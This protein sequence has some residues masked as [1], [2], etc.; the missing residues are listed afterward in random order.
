MIVFTISL[1]NTISSPMTPEQFVREY[2]LTE[3]AKQELLHLKV[4]QCDIPNG[5]L[6]L[7][8]LPDPKLRG[9]YSIIGKS[10]I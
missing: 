5:G 2:Y 4:S 8:H 7:H 9:I 6:C 1:E 3:R 10:T